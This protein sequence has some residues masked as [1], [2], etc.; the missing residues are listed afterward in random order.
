[1]T[2]LGAQDFFAIDW[3]PAAASEYRLTF[4]MRPLR[5]ATGNR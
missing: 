2:D 1:M 5:P 3:L 4:S